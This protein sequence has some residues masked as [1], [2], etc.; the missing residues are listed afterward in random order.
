M[1]DCTIERGLV[2]DLD[3]GGVLWP[4]LANREDLLRLL[5]E[6][7]SLFL[8]LIGG[9]LL[10]DFLRCS[11]LLALSQQLGLMGCGGG[12]SIERSGAFCLV[13]CG[14]LY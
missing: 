8:Q 7:I 9:R 14:D 1:A 5:N 13:L 2:V 4:R 11:N 10:L 3:I 6:I 12:S